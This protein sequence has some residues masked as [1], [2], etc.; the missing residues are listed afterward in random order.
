MKEQITFGGRSLVFNI[1]M[2]LLNFTGMAFLVLG[3]HDSFTHSSTLFR[4]LGLMLL[5]TS[6]GGLVILRGRYLMSSVSRV[7]VGGLFI[8]SGLIKANDPI[9]FSY[10]LEEYFEDGALAFRIK[11]WFGAP[12]FSMESFI[13]QALLFSIII[14]IAEIVLG[15]LVI[16]GGKMKLV[17]Y[18]MLFMMLFFT[19]LTWHTAN[20]DNEITFTDRNTYSVSDPLAQTKIDQSE[21]DTSITVVSQTSSEVVI[22]ET[23]TPQCV[24]DCGCFGDAMKG[25]A[26]RSLTPNESLWKDIVLLYLIFW[27]FLAQWIIK[28]NE[29]RD[30]FWY[31]C[32]SLIVVTFFSWV[33]G[34]YFPVLF[35]FIAIVGGLWIR[36]IGG[37]L[38]GNYYGSAL[39][40]VLLAFGL[41]AYVLAYAPLKDYRPYAIGSNLID[42]MNDGVP[43][44]NADRYVYV[45]SKTGERKEFSESEYT[46]SNIWTKPDWKFEEI[47]KVTIVESILPSIDSIQFNPY[48]DLSDISDYELALPEVK[49]QLAASL[50]EF[51]KLKELTSGNIKEVPLNDFDVTDYPEESYTILDTL[52]MPAETVSG[53]SAQNIILTSERVVMLVA[54]ELR[55]GDWRHIDRLKSIFEQCKKMNVP[56]IVICGD[57]RDEINAF[58]SKYEFYAPFF[59]N[60]GTELKVISRS[61]PTLMVIEKGIIK[62]KYPFRST[63]KLDSFKTKHL[64]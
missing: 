6:I 47:I 55:M 61:N 5:I 33:F 40:V 2:V 51:V 26:G 17:S 42:K 41:V 9:G 19:F 4:L 58:R 15:V 7:I 25:S 23:R 48:V 57:S 60:D 20:C 32:T 62:A 45:N 13:D 18:L 30:N 8:V 1:V 16:L 35:A 21:E 10:K 39:F 63:P 34:W 52:V 24:T 31:T 22:D 11:E 49:T 28:P 44:A 37:K 43:G 46:A 3:F 53:V 12:G 56:F 27:I 64:N 36:T 29:R 59:V 54:K 38:L 14:C 50:R